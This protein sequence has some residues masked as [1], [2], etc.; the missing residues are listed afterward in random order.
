MKPATSLLHSLASHPA[1]YDLIQRAAGVDEVNRRLRESANGFARGEW[2]L[3]VGGG[4]G[5]ASDIGLE[6]THH[7]VVDIDEAKLIGFRRTH[8]GG[9]AVQGDATRLPIVSEVADLVLCRAVSHH[10]DDAE[11]ERLFAEAARALRPGGR[12]LFLDAVAAPSRLRSR[13]LWRYDRGSHPR[14]A[15]DLRAVFVRYFDIVTWTTFT[16]HHAY[17]IGVGI[18]HPPAD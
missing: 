1:L 6:Y 12:F 7:V 13:L 10:L 17:V 4:T 8:A 18:R 9:L 3:D 5:L 2:W 14:D 15:R 16:I 11:L